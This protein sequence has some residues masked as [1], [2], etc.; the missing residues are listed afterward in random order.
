[1][2]RR[3]EK[4]HI[5]HDLV[6]HGT[7][8]KGLEPNKTKLHK[9]MFYKYHQLPKGFYTPMVIIIFREKVAQVVWGKQPFAFVLESKEIKDS[10]M[11]YFHYFWRLAR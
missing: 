2:K 4:K 3:A 11:R 8:L 5:M 6:S 9:K 7:W 1:M 10:F